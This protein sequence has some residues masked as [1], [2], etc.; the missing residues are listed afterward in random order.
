MICEDPFDKT[1]NQGAFAALSI[2]EQFCLAAA[3]DDFH[4]LLRS[5]FIGL[6]HLP[7]SSVSSSISVQPLGQRMLASSEVDFAGG[8]VAL[9]ACWHLGQGT[10]LPASSC[11]IRFFCALKDWALLWLILEKSA[12]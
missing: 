11:L 9:K 6:T 2:F 3:A 8:K 10:F 1:F 12:D 5:F 4:R 7:G